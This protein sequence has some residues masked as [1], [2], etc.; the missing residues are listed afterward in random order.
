[1]DGLIIKQPWINLI[2]NNKKTWE[3]RSKKTHKRGKIALIASKTGTILGECT[4]SDCIEL[5]KQ[6]FEKNRDKHHSTQAFSQTKLYAWI[7]SN[8]K[9]YARPRPYTHPQGA[10][11]WVKN[12][13]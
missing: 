8:P 12:V 6:T 13:C 2:L 5:D 10:I 9:Q 1:M 4:L 3:L 11:I 7:L